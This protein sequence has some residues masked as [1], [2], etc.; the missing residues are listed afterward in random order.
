M[1]KAVSASFFDGCNKGIDICS[2]GIAMRKF[3]LCG[4]N[5]YSLMDK[6]A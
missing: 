6:Y 5:I 2:D 1:W 4:M 3:R